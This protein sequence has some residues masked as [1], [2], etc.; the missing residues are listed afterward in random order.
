MPI[1]PEEILIKIIQNNPNATVSY[2]S[3]AGNIDKVTSVE[4]LSSIF[5][6][7][8]VTNETKLVYPGLIKEASRDNK[9]MFF[10]IYP[11]H[12]KTI[13]YNKFTDP[14]RVVIPRSM[15]QYTFVRR[16]NGSH[17][18]TNTQI[19]FMY[20]NEKFSKDMKMYYCMMN[21][22]SNTYT[23]GVCWGSYEATIN[24]MFSG[25]IDT[26][27]FDDVYHMFFG[28]IF[29]Y[30]LGC[31]G[32]YDYDDLR[33]CV[34]VKKAKTTPGVYEILY[35]NQRTGNYIAYLNQ[36]AESK[37]GLFIPE[38]FQKPAGTLESVIISGMSSYL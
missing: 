4:N 2:R 35:D 27:N 6:N 14:I 1:Q 9:F 25:E 26:F 5:A 32:V 15:F 7:Q 12:V 18:L 30:D 20:D 23:P 10:V 13:K 3:K 37:E 11:S 16:D 21:N 28:T 19:Y 29:N 22:Y 31:S 33:N 8:I 24:Q 34:D 38:K 36:Y 17:L